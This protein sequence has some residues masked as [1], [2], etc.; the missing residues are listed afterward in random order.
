MGPEQ[1]LVRKVVKTH[2]PLSKWF[3]G[4]VH[5]WHCSGSKALA[6]RAMSIVHV[7]L[8]YITMY[9]H[10]MVHSG[11]CTLFHPPPPPSQLHP[12]HACDPPCHSPTSFP[13]PYSSWLL[14]VRIDGSN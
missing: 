6:S 14:A 13:P 10:V 1:D 3:V 9:I 11:Q 7:L 2:G 4:L 8:D 5:D 12:A